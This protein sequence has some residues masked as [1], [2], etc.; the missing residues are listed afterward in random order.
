M[1][2]ADETVAGAGQ[3]EGGP[4]GGGVGD[5]GVDGAVLMADADGGGGAGGVLAYCGIRPRL[6]LAVLGH[7]GSWLALSLVPNARTAIAAVTIGDSGALAWWSD[8]RGYL[9]DHTSAAWLLVGAPH[10]QTTFLVLG[11]TGV[12]VVVVAA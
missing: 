11:T 12:A 10:S 1:A 9:I 4:C 5:R 2:Q 7:G 6:A 3:R 8:T